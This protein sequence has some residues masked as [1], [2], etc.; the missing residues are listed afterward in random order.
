M[1]M[2]YG[3]FVI[4]QIIEVLRVLVLIAAIPVLC[5]LYVALKI[6]IDKNSK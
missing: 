6:Y 3:W 2:F 1:R 4:W 5:K